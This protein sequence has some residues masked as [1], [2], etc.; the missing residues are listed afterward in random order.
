MHDLATIKRQNF[1][2]ALSYEERLKKIRSLSRHE[3]ED[4][5]DALEYV[6]AELS[7]PVRRGIEGDPVD[8]AFQRVR[9]VLSEFNKKAGY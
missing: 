4:L 3:V 7:Q 6:R 5:V 2:A 1:L 8:N 9:Q